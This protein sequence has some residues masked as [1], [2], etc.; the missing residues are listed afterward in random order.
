MPSIT[1]SRPTD[2]RWTTTLPHLI[3][4]LP[5]ES[6]VGFVLRCDAANDWPAGSTAALTGLHPPPMTPPQGNRLA[7]LI[8][9]PPAA[10]DALASL[11]DLPPS[12]IEGLTDPAGLRRSG[13]GSFAVCMACVQEASLIRREHVRH[14]WGHTARTCS[15][16][17]R[18]LRQRCDCAA[19]LRPFSRGSRPFHCRH[20]DRSWG[21]LA[22]VTDMAA[23]D[24]LDPPTPQI[25]YLRALFGRR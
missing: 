25:L 12:D 2:P 8:S 9:P 10:I 21:Q 19:E 5:E 24:R 16:H 15:V 22:P 11:I 6:L 23:L 3:R 7:R 17:R 20:C 18:R 4:P 13:I 1:I 14:H